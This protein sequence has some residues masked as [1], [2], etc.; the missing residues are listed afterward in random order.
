VQEKNF[1]LQKISLTNFYSK[2][3]IPIQPQENRQ[4]LYT[5]SI[6]RLL[7]PQQDRER[8]YGMKEKN[9]AKLTS[10]CLGIFSPLK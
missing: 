5:F 1:N 10:L 3:R 6:L 2:V 9:I 4:P 7:M 8:M